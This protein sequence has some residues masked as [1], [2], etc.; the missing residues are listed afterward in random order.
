M[1]VCVCN[2]G[3]TYHYTILLLLLDLAVISKAQDLL[4]N[5]ELEKTQTKTGEEES[6]LSNKKRKGIYYYCVFYS[7]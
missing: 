5:E 4:T 7:Y 3:T 1:C 6:T 2:N